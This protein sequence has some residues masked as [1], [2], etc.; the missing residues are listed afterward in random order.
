VKGPDAVPALI[1]AMDASKIAW[2][3]SFGHCCLPL[4]RRVSRQFSL[5]FSLP[6]RAGD[7]KY[8][9]VLPGRDLSQ[10]SRMV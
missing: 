1:S 10:E 6:L 2:I 9:M 8:L 3:L 7:G 4:L 5:T